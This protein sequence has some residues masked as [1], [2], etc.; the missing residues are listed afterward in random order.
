[1]P[2][3]WSGVASSRSRTPLQKAALPMSLLDSHR[4]TLKRI[5]ND[6]HNAYSIH[7]WTTAGSPF[8]YGRLVS[9]LV[10]LAAEQEIVYVTGA[11]RSE[12]G[13]LEATVLTVD[14]VVAARVENAD[15]GEADVSAR[16]LP[17]RSIEAVSVSAVES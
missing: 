14:L 17:R 7:G 12:T 1:M 4:D 8:S 2:G 3:R 5:N 6:L 10:L 13:E 9:A 11:Y 16:A 15:S